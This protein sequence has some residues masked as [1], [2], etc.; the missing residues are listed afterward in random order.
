[1]IVVTMMVPESKRRK[2]MF[3]ELLRME[4]LPFNFL[5]ISGDF[6]KGLSA[7]LLSIVTD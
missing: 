5:T 7:N 4:L 1:M 2:A 6:T 3:Q